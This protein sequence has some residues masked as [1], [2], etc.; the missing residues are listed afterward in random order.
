[1]NG[2]E[3][4]AQVCRRR[5]LATLGGAAAAVAIG[6][7]SASAATSREIEA[8]V[9]RAVAELYYLR[10][11]M[12]RAAARAAGVLV[13]PQVLSV[14]LVIGGQYGEGALKI[15]GETDSYWSFR[16]GS[17]GLQAGAQRTRQALFFMSDDVL[18]AFRQGGRARLGTDVDVTIAR[19]RR[20]VDVEQSAGVIAIEFGAAGLLGGASFHGGRYTRITR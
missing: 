9:R 16:A 12:K 17:F 4:G 10:P 5:A 3:A 14:G 6:G 20:Q 19:S 8:G 2:S 1:M 11:E 15:R 7:A 13:V 18:A